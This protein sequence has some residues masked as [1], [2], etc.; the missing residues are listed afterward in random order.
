LVVFLE[1]R[2]TGSPFTRWL[3]KTGVAWLPLSPQEIYLPANRLA[4][5]YVLRLNAGV[6]SARGI[7]RAAFEAQ[8]FANRSA[9]TAV[10][11]DAFISAQPV[12]ASRTRLDARDFSALQCIGTS[13]AL[14]PVFRSMSAPVPH[15]VVAAEPPARDCE[16]QVIVR[17]TPLYSSV[18]FAEQL[19]LLREHPGRPLDRETLEQ[20]RRVTALLGSEPER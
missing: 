17:R 14:A 16:R 4:P 6:E 20:L 1:E 5:G 8:S 3:E 9:A 12:M 15:G 2:Q 18:P 7:N 13:P 19:P 11:P 10:S